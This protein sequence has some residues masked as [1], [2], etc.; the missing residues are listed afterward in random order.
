MFIKHFPTIR[1]YLLH[2]ET[3]T[4]MDGKRVKRLQSDMCHLETYLISKICFELTSFGVTPFSLHDGI[5]MSEA[6][7]NQLSNRLKLDSI[8]DTQRWVEN[9]F[10]Q[11]FDELTPNKVQRILCS[12]P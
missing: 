12:E 4:N 2:Y 11:Y 10:W 8:K 3:I 6:E 9:L 5:Y 7:M 1:N